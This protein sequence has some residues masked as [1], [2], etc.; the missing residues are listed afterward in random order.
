MVL[1]FVASL[2]RVASPSWWTIAEW[3]V[4][5]D[6]A[7]SVVCARVAFGAWVLAL[8]VDARRVNGAV[9]VVSAFDL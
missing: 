2:L 6:T 4:V 8:F 5:G 9:R 7:F 3:S 1:T